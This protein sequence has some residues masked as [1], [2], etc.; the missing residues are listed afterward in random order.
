MTQRT[1]RQHSQEMFDRIVTVATDVKNDQFETLMQYIPTFDC[2]DLL[3]LFDL[4]SSKAKLLVFRLLDPQTASDLFY[5][6]S[7]RDQT[8]ILKHFTD[9]EVITLL[10][11]IKPDD[12]TQIFTEMP[13]K[14][15]QRLL[16]LLPPEELQQAKALLGYPP[17]S[18]W[19]LMT[20]HYVA[21]R[22]HW[23][24]SQVLAHIRK[25]WALSETINVLYVVDKDWYLTWVLSLRDVVLAEK[26]QRISEFMNQEVEKLYARDDRETAVHLM[27]KTWLLVLPVVNKEDILLWIVTADDILL[28]AEEEVTEDFHKWAAMSPLKQDYKETP[29]WELVKKRTPWLLIL[30]LVSLASSWVIYYFEETL[31]AA[32]ALAFFIPLLIDCWWNTGAQSATIMVRALAIW[33]IKIHQWLKA[34]FKELFVWLLIWVSMWVAS[35]L[36]WWFRGWREISIVVWLSMMSIVILANCIWAVLPFILTKFKQDPAVASG[37]LITTI[38]DVT[39]LIVYFLLATRIIL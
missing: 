11:T 18:I 23:T 20:P 10:E 2:D 31:E 4:L 17:E 3:D 5:E 15:T 24:V 36:L 25:K 26:Q 1:P 13:G 9:A 29:I 28:V 27:D 32:I 19:R 7:V 12:R 30:V 14:A 37:P 8:N 16:N 38:V 21:V 6:L 22:E 35:W 33:D 34:I 39:G